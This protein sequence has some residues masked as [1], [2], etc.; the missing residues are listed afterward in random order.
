MTSTALYVRVSTKEQTT[1]NQERELRRWAERL[2]L[3]VVAIYADTMSGARNDRAELAKLL[4]AAHRREFDVLLVWAL[5]RVSREGIGRMVAY[6][7]QPARQASGASVTRALGRYGWT[8]R[9][10]RARHFAWS[11]NRSGADR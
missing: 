7:E 4:T 11:P 5:D 1:D 3:K 9:G 6:V 10:T 8:C 2:G